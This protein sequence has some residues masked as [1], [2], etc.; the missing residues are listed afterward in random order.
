M[1]FKRVIGLVIIAAGLMCSYAKTQKTKYVYDLRTN[2][3]AAP[4]SVERAPVFSWKMNAEGQYGASQTAYRIMVSSSEVRLEN[5]QYVY[6]S[7]KTKGSSSICHYYAGEPLMPCSR[8][9]WKVQVWDEKGKMAESA[10]AWFETALMN[11]GW[12]GAEWIGSPTE[13]LSKYA[14]NLIFDFDLKIPEGSNEAS[15]IWGAWDVANYWGI[16]YSLT[17]VKS[18]V[19]DNRNREVT[20]QSIRPEIIF[21]HTLGGKI[22]EDARV[23]VSAVIKEGTYYGTHHVKMTNRPEE[24][25]RY[26][27][28]LEVDGQKV[29]ASEKTDCFILHDDTRWKQMHRLL[30][31]G[32]EQQEKSE[33]SNIRI[34]DYKHHTLFYHDGTA[35]VGDGT[36]APRIW[37]PNGDVAAPMLR[38]DF[39]ISKNIRQA[40]LY[41]TARGIYEMSLNGK[42]ISGD[43]FNPGWTDYNV[44]LMYNTYDVTA[45]LHQGRNV[46]GAILGEGWWKGVRY[47]NPKWYDCYGA[48]LSLMGKLVIE[49]TDASKDVI[50]TDGDWLCSNDGPV[51]TNSFFDGEDDDAR[52]EMPGWNTADFNVSSWK[53]CRVYEPLNPEVKITPYIGQPV[54]T[55]TVCIARSMTHPLPHTYIYDMGQNLVGIPCIYIKG[56]RGQTITLR[57][58]E[59]KY[60]DVIPTEPVEPYTIEEYKEKKGQIYTDNY[61]SA[62]STDHYTLKGSPEGEVFEPHFTCHGFRYIEITG[63]DAALSL[64]DVKVK[65]LNSLQDGENCMYATSNQLINQLFSNIQWG[66]RG[67]FVSIPT[68]CPQ[69][70]ERAGWSGDAQIFCRTA[71]YNRNVNPFYHRWMTTVRDDQL[72][73][74]G[75]KD[76]NPTSK[77]FGSAFGWADVGIILPWQVYQQYGDKTILEENYEAMKKYVAYNEKR[78]NGGLQNFGGY[79]DWVAVQPTQS[80]LTN[81]CFSAWDVWIMQHVAQILGKAEDEKHYAAL[82]DKIKKIF[83]EKYVDSEGYI[84]SPIGSPVSLDQYGGASSEKITEP[85]R[86]TTQTAYVVPLMMNMVDES[87]AH[88]TAAHLAELVKE[89]GYKLNTG[90]IGTPYINMVLSEYGHDDVAYRLI[91]Q[92]EYPSWLYPVLQGATTMWERWN[93]YTI[94]NGFGPVS[95]NSFNHYAYGAVQDWMMAYSAGIQRDESMPGYQHILLQPRVAGNLT[96]VQ[97]KYN[98]MYGEISST[99]ITDHVDNKKTAAEEN[100]TYKVQIPANATATLTLPAPLNK[101]KVI[102]GK[103]GIVNT[104][105]KEN[106]STI[107]LSSGNYMFYILR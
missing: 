24:F 13:G 11:E 92:Q 62:M 76:V 98:S 60:P 28:T 4:L 26:E 5:G 27:I 3:E 79:G 51:M 25:T 33:I 66:R 19:R 81:T 31:I 88:K 71:T 83:N 1:G 72:P 45:L 87:V 101:I 78:S 77:I 35:H 64:N 74:G 53:K 12:S 29:K 86:I 39:T 44:R 21:Y 89:N 23:D 63:I 103:K 6:D 69:R 67:N 52:R 102:S 57:Y 10:P 96:Y 16:R 94:K 56:K 17:K 84:I 47:Y 41:V 20:R 54:R 9:F 2:Y 100:F 42:N 58:A 85:R 14:S 59:M 95:M 50:V 36:T 90:F 107:N 73:E 32:Y 91:E 30:A 22:T 104:A 75:F 82:F 80:D 65:V 7:G 61:R 70:D 68:D 46:I 93:S 43:F 55:D 40:R 49:Y 18:V 105:S 34:R 48:S 38:R 8:Y 106:T 37:V 99:W 15:F 97:A